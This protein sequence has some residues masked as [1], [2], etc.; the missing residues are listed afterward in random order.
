MKVKT[1]HS[2]V[3]TQKE[4]YSKRQAKNRT[5]DKLTQAEGQERLTVR[6][7]LLGADIKCWRK[8]GRGRTSWRSHL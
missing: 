4:R 6:G 1:S 7:C 5:C 3:K 8:A 2:L